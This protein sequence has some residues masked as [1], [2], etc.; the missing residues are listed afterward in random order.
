VPGVEPAVAVHGR[1]AHRALEAEAAAAGDGGR[2]V[3]AH[4]A[5]PVQP[6]EVE[7]LRV[8]GVL[9]HQRQRLR[10]DALP[11]VL[12]AQP[13]AD[14][15]RAQRL[16]PQLDQAGQLAAHADAPDRDVGGAR[17]GGRVGAGEV[18]G[19][20]AT[21]RRRHLHPALDLGV[22]AVAQDRV[23]VRGEQRVER[24]P[25]GTDDDGDH[26]RGRKPMRSYTVA[27]VASAIAAARSAPIASMRSSSAGSSSS[28]SV[29]VRMGEKVST[30]TSARS[31][32]KSP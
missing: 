18:G 22:L 1:L 17:G 10:H 32:L 24:H 23:G 9:H 26:A 27:S 31:F 2:G 5:L 3:V 13:E 8:E 25:P 7:P 19:V 28:S 29:R 14:G 21:V 15:G 11:A 16:V 12:V 30:T 20:L 6:V 4:E